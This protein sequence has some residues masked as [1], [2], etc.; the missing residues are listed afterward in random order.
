MANA[1]TFGGLYL[2]GTPPQEENLF[3]RIDAHFT[4][5]KGKGFNPDQGGMISSDQVGYTLGS[6]E[7]DVT[8]AINGQ[9]G[10]VPIESEVIFLQNSSL[11]R[12]NSASNSGS[13]KKILSYSRSGRRLCC[14]M[15]KSFGESFPI[16]F[17][18]SFL[19]NLFNSTPKASMTAEKAERAREEAERMAGR[20]AP[21][22]VEEA[23]KK[24]T[25]KPS[26]KMDL[27][28]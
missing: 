10:V 12:Y 9:K 25:A 22:R 6:Y 13:A 3:R 4:V 7:K 17:S 18:S 14:R 24:E 28:L 20:A 1:V 11:R 19:R 15:E 2:E 21:Q 5:R 23:A 16:H 27:L 26:K 8:D